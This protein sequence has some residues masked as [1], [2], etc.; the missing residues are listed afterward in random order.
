MLFSVVIPMYNERAVIRDTVAAL[1]GTLERAAAENGWRYEILFSD[2]GSDDG[3][4]EIVRDAA[5]GLSLNCGSVAVIRSEKNR[6][7]GAA[8]RKGMLEARGLWRLFTDSDLAYGAG[9]IPVGIALFARRDD[10][11]AQAANGFALAVARLVDEERP[12][13]GR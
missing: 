7:K 4:G 5:R 6:G 3:C 9:I 13:R 8:V 12:L 1:A 11:D 2:D 10:V